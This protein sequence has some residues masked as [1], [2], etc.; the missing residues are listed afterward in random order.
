MK[1]RFNK[2]KNFTDK[3]NVIE[4]QSYSEFRIPPR[5]IKHDNTYQNRKPE[6]NQNNKK[7]LQPCR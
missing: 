7:L 5:Q 1:H 3:T 4:Y 6:P 2:A